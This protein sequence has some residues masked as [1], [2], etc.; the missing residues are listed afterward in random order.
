MEALALQTGAPKEHW[1]DN[2]SCIYDIEVKI[3]TTRVNHF[4]IPVCFLKEQF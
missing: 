3:F 1:E 4:G 2:T